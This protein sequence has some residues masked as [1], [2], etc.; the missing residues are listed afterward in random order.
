MPCRRCTHS[1]HSVRMMIVVSFALASL[2][3][4]GFAQSGLAQTGTN[5][6]SIFKN[7]FVTGDYVVG[8]WVELPPDGSGYASGTISIPDTK[9]PPLPDGVRPT[10]PAGADIVAAYLY[11]AT[12]EG[13]GSSFAGQQAYF[14]GYAVTG[15]ILGNPNAPV[16][17]SAGGCSGSALGSKTMRTYRAD[18]RPYLPLDTNPASS[19]FGALLGTGNIPVRL[20]DSGSN[21]NTTPNALG[22]SLV[23]IYRVLS[24]TMPLNAIVLYDGAYSPS[25]A[26]QGFSQTVAGFYQPSAS[27][28]AKLT[29]IVANGQANKSELVYLNNHSQPLPSL[30]GTLPPFPG[31]YGSWD[32]PT[33]LLSQYGYVNSADTSETTLV[34]PSAKNSGCVSWGTIILSTTVQDSD[35]DGLPDVWETAQGYTDAVSGQWV[36]LPGANPSVKDLFVEVDYLSNMDGSAGSYL[37]SHLPKQAALDAVGGAFAAQ[38]INVHFDLGVNSLGQNVYPGDPYV[39][40]YPVSTPNPLPT[41]TLPAPSGTGGNGVS[42]GAVLCTGATGLCAF[43]GQPAVGWKGGFEFF[44]TQPTLGNFQPGR[45]QS[46]HYVLFGHSLGAPRSFWSTLGYGL[47]EPSIPQLVSIVNTGSSAIVTIRSPQGVVKPGDCPNA[48]IPACLDAN[49]DR[50]S[51][52]GAVGQPAL[53]ATYSLANSN[54]RT[55]NNVTTFTITTANVASGTYTFSNEPQLGVAYMG[56]TSTSGH[57][58]FGGGADSA[59]TLGLWAADDPLNCQGDPSQPLTSGQVYCNNQLGSVLV[60]NG[61]LLHELGHTLTLTHGGTYYKDSINPSLPSYEDNCKPNFLSTMNYLFQVRGFVDG[62]FDFSGQTMAPLNEAFPPLNEL[63]GIGLDLFSAQPAAHLTRWYSAPNALDIQLQKTSGGRYATAHCDGTPLTSADVPA[64]RVDGGLAA[65]GTYSGP[66]DWNND[67]VVPNALIAPGV[68]L[69]YNG[70]VGDP[71]FTGFNDWQSVDLQQMNARASSFGFSQ[72]GGLKAAGGGLKAGGGGID[73]DGGGLKAGGGGLKAGGGGLKAAGGGIDQDAD[74][75]NSTVSSPT[76]LTCS[77][78]QNNI[79]GCVT[80]S[81]SLLENA[82]SVPLTWTPPGFG[83]IRK[84]NVWR[85]VGSFATTQQVQSNLSKFSIIKTLTGTP[86]VSSFIDPNVKNNTTYTYFVT[87]ANKQGVQSAASTALVVAVK[88]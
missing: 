71:A 17:W 52:T 84:Y 23:V 79:P 42:E 83:Q 22:A 26:A 66:L 8:G 32:N 11:W 14:N 20:V 58:D 27:P 69:N 50:V 12:V 65:G 86:P 38:Q 82:R 61:T 25:N 74:T 48:A 30:Y 7:Y 70:A 62:G 44:Q 73:D 33:W 78:P 13:N 67:L 35:G 4:T 76:G 24:P 40:S 54:P 5:N 6:L 3:L 15:T 46:Y 31:I 37:H 10:V 63:S 81:G 56:P 47:S 43:P 28:V 68:D 85:A 51:V 36:A 77:V 72:A 9:Q 39:I 53:N 59:V 80:S 57:S 87:D 75:A 34:D 29:H 16:S 41:G 2:L 49:S 19:T 21:G 55:V 60:Q 1:R 64:V 88:F 18:V 45:A